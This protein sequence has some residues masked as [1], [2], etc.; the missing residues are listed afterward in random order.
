ME[1]VGATSKIGPSSYFPEEINNLKHIP[2]LRTT[3]AGARLETETVLFSSVDKILKQLSI[4]ADSIGA[5]I[6]NCSSFNPVPSLAASVINQFKMKPSV[7]G[8]NLSGMGCAASVIAVDVAQELLQN[9]RNMRILVAG[10]ENI[11]SMLYTGKQRSMLITNCL[12]RLGG[13]AFVLSNR[14]SDGRS[15]KYRLEHLVRTHLSSDEAYGAVISHEDE[16]DKVGIKI[17]KEVMHVAARALTLNV[18]KLAP[19]ILHLS[20]K[21]LY[22][23]NYVARKVFKRNMAEYVPDFTAAVSHFVIHPGGKAVIDTVEKALHLQ[24][25]H[26]HPNRAA[27]TR[28]GNT[29][30]SSTWYALAYIETRTGVKRGERVWQLA[31]GS[32]FKCASA[33]WRALKPNKDQHDAWT[34]PSC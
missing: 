12:F 29:S 27:F 34:G 18:V 4:P 14:Q 23:G 15:A 8:Y 20:E 6:I 26:A 31:F 19:L 11:T 5:V 10:S 21:I 16:D 33:I 28:F 2:K 22:G 1:K 24:P 17:G 32:G 3:F 7:L 25:K 13:V 30:S 9:H